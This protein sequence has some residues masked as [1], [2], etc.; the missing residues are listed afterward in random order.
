MNVIF[1][2]ILVGILL[3]GALIGVKK[4][5]I[6][7]VAKPVKFVLA[8]ILAFS[9]AKTVGEFLVE[10]IIGPAISH[11]FSS[12]LVEKYSDMTVDTVERDLP[13]LVKM[14]AGI[15]GVDVQS[16]A[17]SAGGTAV[18]EA[19]ASSVTA[20]VVDIISLIFGFVIAYLASKILLK[21]LFVFVNTVVNNGITGKL[22][23]TLG[24]VLT[25]FLA[26]VVGWAFTSVSEFVLNIPAIASIGGVENFTGGPV[27]R[28]FRT[29][30][31]L[32]LLLSF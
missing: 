28:L 7:T 11:K 20:P 15:C 21:F 13:T 8:L 18:I 16:V 2:I 22:N 23:K 12:V 14:A 6:N 19:V 24:C 3:A 9:L 26:F 17:S 31:P 27:Y 32:D 29:F 4:G 25:L 5:F 1:D 10:P 30:T